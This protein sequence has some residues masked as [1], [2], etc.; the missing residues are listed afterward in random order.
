MEPGSLAWRPSSCRHQG[1][2]GGRPTH[3]LAAETARLSKL[4]NATEAPGAA[5]EVPST[6]PYL[7]DI[8]LDDF[9]KALRK[10]SHH[11]ARTYDGVHP[12]HMELLSEQQQSTVVSFSILWRLMALSLRPS[13]RSSLF[14]FP[15]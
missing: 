15:S 2:W 9:R 11:T 7:P 12:K 14:L 13:E 10:F 8:T 5:V 3:L 4:W 6:K 1:V